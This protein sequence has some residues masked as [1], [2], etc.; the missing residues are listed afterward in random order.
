MC[1]WMTFLRAQCPHLGYL[2]DSP[3]LTQQEYL[4]PP[5]RELQ[6]SSADRRPDWLRVKHCVHRL[7]LDAAPNF[8]CP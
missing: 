8:N 5:A 2:V 6:G 7:G 4:I 1:L 3:A